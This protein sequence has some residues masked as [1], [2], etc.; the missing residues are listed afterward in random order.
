MWAHPPVPA[1]QACCCPGG[2]GSKNSGLGKVHASHSV[3]PFHHSFSFLHTLLP[4]TFIFVLS[5]TSCVILS[6]INL[7]KYSNKQDLSVY[8][9]TCAC[10]CQYHRCEVFP[11]IHSTLINT[12]TYN[13]QYNSPVMNTLFAMSASTS[14]STLYVLQCCLL[15]FSF[16]AG[17]TWPYVWFF[18]YISYNRLLHSFVS[19][20]I[21][22]WMHLSAQKPH[23]SIITA[24]FDKQ[25]HCIVLTE[26]TS[27]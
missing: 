27:T 2:Y 3:G 23:H 16:W 15:I 10:V 4:I 11:S 13:F 21:A 5:S 6:P 8:E 12:H 18:L 14:S 9:C 24:K 17:I 19:C 22:S 20:H 26:F 7:K 25:E 1:G